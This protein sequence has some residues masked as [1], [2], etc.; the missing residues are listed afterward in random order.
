M[1][2]AWAARH[3]IGQKSDRPVMVEGGMGLLAVL[4]QGGRIKEGSRKAR[5][6][7]GLQRDN[8]ASTHWGHGRP[9]RHR[10]HCSACD[11]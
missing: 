10:A 6:M 4:K 5:G 2:G 7:A 8:T 3:E 1:L 11:A 9:G